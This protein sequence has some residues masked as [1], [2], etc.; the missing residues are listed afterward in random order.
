[1]S[2]SRRRGEENLFCDPH[3]NGIRE[4]DIISV[5]VDTLTETFGAGEVMAADLA[6]GGEQ[7][8]SERGD[9]SGK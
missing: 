1:M 2:W 3:L 5:C 4:N 6:T 7:R 9:K 8:G